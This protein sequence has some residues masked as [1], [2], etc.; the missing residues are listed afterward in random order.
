MIQ[1]LVIFYHT[2]T[3]NIVKFYRLHR[4]YSYSTQGI[5]I[6]VLKYPEISSSI[7]HL[8]ILSTLN[9]VYSALI[10]DLQ[11]TVK[12][13]FFFFKV[14][15]L[16]N[17]YKLKNSNKSLLI[18]CENHKNNNL[19]VLHFTFSTVKSTM[20]VPQHFVFSEIKNLS[21]IFC[22]WL[23]LLKEWKAFNIIV[24]AFN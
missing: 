4:W 1:R 22:D 24:E 7:H 13:L 14:I 20:Y 9:I 2:R 18:N 10:V 19:S 15:I 6:I 16:T 3:H 17:C 11:A 12:F 5:P 21:P 23:I 8:V